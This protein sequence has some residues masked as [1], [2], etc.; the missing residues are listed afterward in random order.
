MLFMTACSSGQKPSG[1]EKESLGPDQILS[2][3]TMDEKISQMII[4]AIRTWNDEDVTDLSK[5]PALAEALRAHQYG[6]IILFGSNVSDTEQLARLVSD[7]QVNN[8]Q[9][10]G[11]SAHIP[12]FLP[13]D[14]EGGIVTRLTM[15]TRM[16]GNMAIGATGEKAADN[17]LATGKVIGEELSALGFNIDFAPDIDVNN[18][19]AN[20]VIGTRSFSD[21][22]ELVA[23]LGTR[24]DDA[25]A[26]E[27]FHEL[28]LSAGKCSR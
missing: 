18:N 3:M 14:E 8:A 2:E 5:V 24:M 19:A 11:V 25:A 12:Y 7:L 15:G 26:K 13:L 20:P 10:E 23:E 22:A 17:A 6:G 21:D 16:T 27:V 1:N 4:P 28:Y 9:I